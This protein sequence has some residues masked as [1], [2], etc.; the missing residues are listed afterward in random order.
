M[1]VPFSFEKK[2]VSVTDG[3]TTKHATRQTKGNVF[4]KLLESK[5]LQMESGILTISP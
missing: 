1:G 2:S 5:V 4:S 3:H